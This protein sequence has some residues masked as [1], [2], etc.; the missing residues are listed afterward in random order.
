MANAQTSNKPRVLIVDD[1]RDGADSLAMLLELENYEV[2]T[3]YDGAEGV[4]RAQRFRPALVLMDLDMPV[5]DGITAA[6]ALSRDRRRTVLVAL[7]ARCAPDREE[8]LRQVGFQ[9]QLPKPVDPD[10]LL[11]VLAWLLAEG[12]GKKH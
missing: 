7:S 5:L 1:N 10:R 6:S 4:E 9:V 11:Q 3:A 8:E 2:A 12:E